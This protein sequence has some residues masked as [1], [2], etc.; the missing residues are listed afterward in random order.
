MY[1]AGYREFNLDFI[2]PVRTSRGVISRK[3]GFLISIAR[4]DDPDITGTGECSTLAGLGYDDKAEYEDVLEGL[5]RNINTP[6]NVLM[7]EYREWPSICFGLETAVLDLKKGGGGLLF[8]SPF[9]KGTVPIPINGLVWMG[10]YEFMLSQIDEKIAAG[11]KVIKLKIGAIDFESEL[12]LLRYIRSRPDSSE[13]TIRLDANGAFSCGEVVEKLYA[14][15]E[16]NIHSIE[17]PLKPGNIGLMKDI[18]GLSPI[19]IALDEELIGHHT[20]EERANLIQAI[21]PAYIILKPSLLGGFAACDD[22]I[23]VCNEYE[24]GY[25]ITSALESNIGLNAIAQYTA[26][27]DTKGLPQGLG[28][29]GLFRNNFPSYMEIVNGELWCRRATH[30]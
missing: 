3:S 25:W 13:I 15:A 30:T 5:C 20:H 22:W 14:L 19:P 11:F 24:I 12:N 9:T 28:T 26:C 8:D 2:K 29:G 23:K 18:C 17:Q 7:E 1:T 16:F 27:V 6:F 4:E 10:D 21:K